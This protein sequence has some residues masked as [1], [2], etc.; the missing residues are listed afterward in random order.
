MHPLK[1]KRIG[2]DP[3]NNSL[4]SSGEAIAEAGAA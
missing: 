3:I 1:R 2:N 4:D